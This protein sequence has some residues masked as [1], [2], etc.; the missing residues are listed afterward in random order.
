MQKLPSIFV[1]SDLHLDTGPFEWPE[2]AL[3][4][5]LIIV[6]GDL[7]NGI[8][9]IDFLCKPGRPLVFVPGNHDF[10]SKDST[11]DMF[12]MYADMKR[13]AAG[14]N[15][16]VL[17]D[18]EVRFGDVRIL[19]TPLW[20]DFGG[21][22]TE[23]MRASFSH[24]R[25]YEY[26]NVRSWYADPENMK[27]HVESAVKFQR[28]NQPDAAETGA[29]TPLVAFS[30]HRKSIE[31]IRSKL[32]EDFE[33]HTILATHMAPTYESLRKSG[34]VREHALDPKF[35]E[36]R[37]RDN[38]D[39][40]RVAGYASDLTEL[41]ETYRGHLDLAVH[42]HIHS[43]LDI[44]CGSTRVVANP[45]GGYMGPLTEEGAN[46]L[47][48]FGYRPSA[49]SIAKSQAAFAEYPYWGDNWSFEPQKLFHLEA[50]LTPALQPLVDE[51]LPQLA[52]LYAEVVEL[53]PHIAHETGAIRCSVQEA[54]I[55][56]AEKFVKAV[57]GVLAPVADA[58]DVRGLHHGL[59]GYLAGLCLPLPKTS[60]V[61]RF[62]D[63][64]DED[65]DP[66]VT[67]R[68]ALA[69]MEQLL[70][71]IP[72]VLTVPELARVRYAERMKSVIDLVSSK[73]LV[74]KLIASTPSGHWRKLYFDLGCLE[75]EGIDEDCDDVGNLD[76][77]I[78]ELINGGPPPRNAYLSVRGV[79]G[80]LLPAP[81]R[82]VDATKGAW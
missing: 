69:A 39:L 82:A 50:G 19:G 54:A 77:Q 11:T 31:F 25:D 78:D 18:E 1:V 2:A 40:A 72:I 45:R 27:L 64:F 80:T 6:A 44:V 48:F 3:A 52:E 58:F 37:G 59:Y 5:D 68:G 34:T 57:E 75:L 49:D 60:L 63:H 20:T 14:T 35:W 51:V 41:F 26:I 32:N 7:A 76:Q 71:T 22:N 46:N 10:W 9:D 38:T 15:V 55:A 21:G 70:T 13:A 61:P 16:H 56:R 53:A 81:E 73:G 65:L 79:G 47:A 43:S 12:E 33:G 42:G 62:E 30:L 4:A 74:P 23:L 67:L 17:W 24:S 36:C 8:F 28:Y 29:F 66:A